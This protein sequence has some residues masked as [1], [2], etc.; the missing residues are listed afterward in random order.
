MMFPQHILAEPFARLP[1]AF[2][3]RGEPNDWV[4]ATRPGQR[5]HSF[6]EGPSFDGEGAL[7]LVDVPHGRIFRVTPDGEWAIVLEYDGEP[8]GLA[9]ASDGRLL[10][11]DYRRGL[12]RYDPAGSGTET[13]CDRVNTEAFR[14]LADLA[15][16]AN[17][18]IWMTDPG[19]SSLSDPTGRLFCLRNGARE[20]ELML[21]NLPY[22]N[23]VAIG[24]DG[25][26]VLVSVT[27]ANAIWRLRTDAPTSG[28]PMAGTF[29][30]L[31]GGLGPDGLAVDGMGRIAV[32]QAQAGRAYLFNALGD[33]VARI[34]VPDGL[35]TT[36][37][38]F[39][40]DG[41]SL[42]IVEAQ[43]G[44]IYRAEMPSQANEVSCPS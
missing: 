24:P 8:H 28:R 17:G 30:Q 9:F 27:R 22:P 7:W 6:L 4:R 32:A 40:P 29:I 16:A 13:L 38:R 42:F 3:F 37:V 23:S 11:A 18:D 34:D 31:S 12:L 33:P 36:A 43:T 26:T 15:V 41:R 10:I 35:W 1:A 2:H 20:A 44:S 21:A 14:G 19:R 25:S 5:L 39:A